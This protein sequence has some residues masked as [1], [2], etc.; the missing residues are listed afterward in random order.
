MKLHFGS[1]VA[2]RV[3]L[4]FVVLGLLAACSSGPEKPKPAELAANPG[5]L[6]VRLAWT[7]KVGAVDLAMDTKVS[8]TMVTV[9]NSEGV[10]TAFD[11]ATGAELW[12]AAVGAPIA[13]GVGSDG[14]FTAAV[15]RANDLLVLDGG[16]ELWRQKLLAPSFTAPLVAGGRVFVLA[17]DRSVTAFDASSGRKLWSQQRPGESLVLRQAGVLL[18]VGDTL[19][20]GMGGR[21][22]G[23]HPGNGSI[24][25]ETA[26]ATPR[27][28][29][30]IERLVDLVGRVARDGAVVCARAF[31]AAVGCVDAARGSLLWSKPAIGSIGVHGDDKF[32]FGV[33]SDGKV[34][35]WRRGDG[36]RAWVSERLLYR[37]LTAPLAVGRS[38]VVGDEA[39]LVHWL[40]RDDGSILTRM[41]TDG[42]AVVAGPVLAS[43]TLIVVTRNGNI[44]GFKPE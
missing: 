11:S 19:V 26:I 41:A 20:A 38:V 3:A 4:V 18:A 32:V 6:G 2:T 5:L 35:A 9:A 43:G 44:F 36:D 27:G 29:N 28:T 30:D 17:A 23:L 15:T 22:A 13:A 25:W 40:S 31:Q 39:G 16:R 1:T 21:L 24:R 14:K 37:S 42:S 33:E 10:L 34:I 7:A 8:G 12:R